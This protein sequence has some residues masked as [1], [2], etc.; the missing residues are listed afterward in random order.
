MRQP[1]LDRLDVR[2]FVC[3]WRLGIKGGI[4]IANPIPAEFEIPSGEISPAI[5]TAVAEAAEMGIRGR[6]VT[7][8]L[9]A[10]L[11][12]VTKGR[13]L[14]ANIAL[15]RNNAKIAARIAARFARI[16]V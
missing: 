16:D 3:R 14:A 12:D 6:D 4:V 15:V 9:L 1:S 8:Y 5:E 13:S 10:R 11:A 2:L 7:P